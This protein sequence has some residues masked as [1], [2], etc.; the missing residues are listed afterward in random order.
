MDSRVLQATEADAGTRVDAFVAAHC[1]V[2]RARAQ[3]LLEGATVNG[4]TVKASH[5]LRTGDA[6]E[7]PARE[8]EV[9]F[10]APVFQPESVELPPILF[11]DEDLLVVNKPRGLTVHAGAGETGATLV[12]ILRAHGRK[13]S[14][15]GPPE[16]AGIMHRLDKDT[17]G[18]MLVCKTDEAHWKLATDFE[19]RRV[20]KTYRALVCGIPPVRGRIEAPI[21]RHEN[22]RKKMTISPSGRFA[23]TEYEIERTWEKFALVRINLL[24]GRT[25]QIRVHLAYVGHAVV[26]DALYGGYHRALTLAPHEEARIAIENLHGQALHAARLEFEHP[27]TFADLSFEAEFPVVVQNL[28]MTLDSEGQFVKLGPGM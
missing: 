16:R 14:G 12:D 4:K 23:V 20:K 3:K 19:A 13:L 8:D 5:T 7:L 1:G 9:A 11:E 2:S 21:A 24:T 26:G 25:H 27:M 18:V 6:V 17:S 10:V 22:M 15:V 28:V